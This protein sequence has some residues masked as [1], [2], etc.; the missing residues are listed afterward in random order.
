MELSRVA[1]GTFGSVVKV[2]KQSLVIV[3]VLFMFEQISIF[4]FIDFSLFKK[5]SF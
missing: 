4:L 1:S 5:I 2:S 3:E